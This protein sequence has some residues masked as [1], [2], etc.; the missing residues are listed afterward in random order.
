MTLELLR[1]FLG[2]HRARLLAPGQGGRGVGLYLELAQLLRPVRCYRLWVGK[3]AEM[4]A[5]TAALSP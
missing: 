2:T 4:V 1:R 3:H 5:L